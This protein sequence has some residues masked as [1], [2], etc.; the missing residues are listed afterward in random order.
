MKEILLDN[1]IQ[2]TYDIDAK[3]KSISKEISLLHEKVANARDKYLSD[4]LDEE[5][6]K[7][8][9]MLTKI[10]IEQLESE[11]QQM[12]SESKELDIKTK[13]ENAL[14]STENLV[15]LYQQGDLLTKRT[16]GCLI[17]P[18]KVE[19]DGKSLQTPKM[20]IV[21]QCIYQY[22]NELGNKKTDIR[23]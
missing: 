11:L 2:F 5:D 3:R 15:N 10:Q 16:I 6:Y 8:I 4:K 13:I 23:E 9:K 18:E 19:F 14:D 7:E 17:F 22:N 21:A 12:V 20:N 1:Y